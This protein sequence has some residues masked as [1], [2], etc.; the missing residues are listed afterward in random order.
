[1]TSPRDLP[2]PSFDDCQAQRPAALRAAAHEHHGHEH[3]HPHGHQHGH[4][5]GHGHSHAHATSTRRLALALLVT[6]LFLVAE[7]VGG[8]LSN[9]VALIADAGHML[10][11]A[12]ALGLSLFVAW[13]SRRPATP[14]RTYGHL[15][16]EIL[17]AFLNGA[18]LLLLSA[19]ILVESIGRLR[20]PEPVGGALMLG[21]AIAG[22]A[23]NSLSA[24]LLHGHQGDSLNLRGAYLHVL[25]DLLGSV[26][27]ILAAL[28]VQWFGWTFADPIASIA[29]TLLIIRGAW[30]LVRE[31]VE[32]LLE[33]APAHIDAEALRRAM[34]EVR[35]VGAV[36]DLH[37]WTLTSGVVAM[38]AHAIAPAVAEHPRVLADL[39]EAAER[40]GIRHTTIQLEGE[41]LA[42]CCG[43]FADSPLTPATR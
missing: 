8:I 26:A 15:R 17:A 31:A 2:Q 6:G 39:H 34:L 25:S 19:W 41:P 9:S 36:H 42:A 33:H 18:T 40:F 23:A 38:S 24:W 12:G 7:L 13:F 30:R 16:W 14:Q 10:T 5:H 32:V 28:A 29:V 27:V 22:L 1:M 4:D 20:A 11:D 37:V 21:I 35:G 3:G 43:D